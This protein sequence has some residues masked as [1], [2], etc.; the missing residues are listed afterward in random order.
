MSLHVECQTHNP[1]CTEDLAAAA[2]LMTGQLAT[3]AHDLTV[4][5]WREE[6]AEEADKL[7]GSHAHWLRLRAH[8]VV[9]SPLSQLLRYT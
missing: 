7:R 2:W 5:A 4:S 1:P 3:H 6:G 8:R 9:V